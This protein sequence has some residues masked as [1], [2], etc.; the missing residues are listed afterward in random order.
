MIVDRRAAA[1]RARAPARAAHARARAD[2]LTP[3]AVKRMAGRRSRPRR[4]RRAG[5]RYLETLHPKSIALG[6]DRVRDRARA[7]ARRHR[8]PGRS[9]WAARTARA[10]RARCSTRCCAAQAIASG[11]TRRRTCC[12]TTSACASTARRSTTRRWSRRSTR[13]RTR[14]SPPTADAAHV[15]R[16]RHAGRAVAVRARR[17]S[18]RSILEVGPGGPARRG[19]RRRRRCRR[20]HVGRPRS[21]RLSRPHARGHRTREG[22]H[23]SPRTAGGVRRARS[24]AQR[25]RRTR[26]AIGAR[27]SASAATTATSTRARSGATSVPRGERFG[28]PHPALRGAYQLANAA[29]ALAAL[30]VPARPP[31]GRARRRSAR[32]ADACRTAGPLQVLPGRP[33][34]VLDVAHNPH[35]AR[36]LAR[37][38]G[39]M[40]FHPRDAR[41]VSACSPTR[42]STA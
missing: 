7:P 4:S 33:T 22:R 39:A 9:P 20:A 5:S 38:L 11:C 30:D 18:T 24:A 29:T 3:A 16:V 42:T 10:R 35:A 34:I 41:G 19:Q 23:L 17:A 26:A 37:C 36:A 25:R 1:R 28:L 13:S 14:A 8:L 6:L 2:V 40:G 31:A 32:A 27:C 21:R 15:F 12:A